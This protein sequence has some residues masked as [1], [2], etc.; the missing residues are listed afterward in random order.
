MKLKVYCLGIDA[1]GK[2]VVII[3]SEDARELGVHPWSGR[4]TIGVGIKTI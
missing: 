1:A 3:N 4:L 2:T